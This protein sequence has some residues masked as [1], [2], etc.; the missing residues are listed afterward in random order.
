MLYRALAVLVVVFWLTMIGLLVRKEAGPAGSALREVPVEHVVKLILVHGEESD[1]SIYSEKLRLGRL[2]IRPQMHKGDRSRVVEFLGNLQILIPGM[3]R[4][5]VE[6]KGDLELEKDLQLR[7]F[8]IDLSFRETGA[9]ATPAY[10]QII[11]AP[12]ENLLTCT[13][14]DQTLTYT[15]DD[16]GRQKALRE[17]LDPALL[18]MV[19]GQTKSMTPPVIKALQSS[20]PYH[21]QRIDT[22]LVTIEQSGQTLLSIDVSQLGTILRVK[23]LLG[24]SLAPDDLVP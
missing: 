5:R 10:A 16:A 19:Q 17:M 12:A 11:V 21:G 6:W 23:T 8:T 2:R 13:W 20:M 1:L 9:R 7:R 4:Q 14:L 3:E 24:Y 22:Y 18:Q 15:L